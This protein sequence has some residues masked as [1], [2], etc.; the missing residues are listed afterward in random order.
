MGL[1][2]GQPWN[3]PPPFSLSKANLKI[4]DIME[5]YSCMGLE[6]A[7]ATPFSHNLGKNPGGPKETQLS[8]R[9]HDTE[10]KH[11]A[12]MRCIVITHGSLA[13][14][15]NHDITTM[16]RQKPPSHQTM[17]WASPW[18]VTLRTFYRQ[19]LSLLYFSFFFW[20]FRPRLARELLLL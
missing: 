1:E 12:I 4:L 8:W 2:H 10:Q 14:T 13:K 9:S 15:P 18:S 20:N 6:A 17:I 16:E 5:I 11:D 3:L 19:I 7:T